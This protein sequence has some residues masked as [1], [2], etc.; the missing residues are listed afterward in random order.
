MCEAARAMLVGPDLVGRVIARPFIG[1]NGHYT[2]T[3][4][5]RDFAVPQ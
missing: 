5:R 3:E 1:S 2:R 4:N